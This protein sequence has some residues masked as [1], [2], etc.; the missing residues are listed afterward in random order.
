MRSEEK[1]LRV[2]IES[3]GKFSWAQREGAESVTILYRHLGGR[4]SCFLLLLEQ[5]SSG[6]LNDT[7]AK[8]TGKTRRVT[9]VA[10]KCSRFT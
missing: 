5:K 7:F 6:W 1:C 3:V 2:C 10:K 9:N 4:R 8:L